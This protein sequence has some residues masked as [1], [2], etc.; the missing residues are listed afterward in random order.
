MKTIINKPIAETYGWLHAG[1]TAVDLPEEPTREVFS[2]APGETKTVVRTDA[3]IYVRYEAELPEG[4][5]FHFIEIKSAD[6]PEKTRVFLRIPFAAKAMCKESMER[7]ADTSTDQEMGNLTHM[8]I[9]TPKKTERNTSCSRNSVPWSVAFGKQS[10]VSWVCGVALRM[11]RHQR[12]G[13]LQRKSIRRP[14]QGS[15]GR[16]KST[17][18]SVRRMT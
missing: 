4:A 18:I 15:S 17:R 13:Q 5:S 10:S 11:H 16:T 12:P 2:L 8:N 3:D 7:I 14:Q 9:M 1:G 6:G